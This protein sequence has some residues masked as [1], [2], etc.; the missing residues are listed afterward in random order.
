MCDHTPDRANQNNRHWHIDP[1]TEKHRLEE[2]IANADDDAPHSKNDR[3]GGAVIVGENVGNDRSQYQQWRELHNRENQHEQPPDTCARYTREDQADGREGR[4][5]QGYTENAL[6]YAAN[7]LHH[8]HDDFLATLAGQT[9]RESD[10]S[11]PRPLRVRQHEPGNNDGND[12]LNDRGPEASE[13][14]QCLGPELPQL[15]REPGQGGF[16]VGGG[17]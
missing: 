3:H 1:A 4:L 8:Q 17:L 12:R 5:N 6:R 9:R 15:W 2:S 11:L 16:Q 13:K 14:A 10:R 7:G